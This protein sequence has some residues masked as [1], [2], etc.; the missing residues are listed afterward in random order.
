MTFIETPISNPHK[1]THL[2][3]DLGTLFSYININIHECGKSHELPS[4]KDEKCIDLIKTFL[5][6]FQIIEFQSPSKNINSKTRLSR[7]VPAV[8]NDPMMSLEIF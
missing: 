1:A 3:T 7:N 5:T 2:K 8:V 4:P 6:S